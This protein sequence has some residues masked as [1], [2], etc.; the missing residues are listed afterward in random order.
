MKSHPIVIAACDSRFEYDL[1]R[2]PEN[3]I[4][5]TAWEKQLWKEPLPDIEKEKSL[6]KYHNFCTVGHAL[7]SKLEEKF[8]VCVVCD[9]HSYNWRRWDKEVPTCNL[10]TSN[11]DNSRFGAQVESWRQLLASISGSYGFK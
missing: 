5:D 4:F 6:K 3:A 2:G 8:S 7:I 9:M 10:G 11:I 1:N